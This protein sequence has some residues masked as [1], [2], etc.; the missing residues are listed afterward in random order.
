[1]ALQDDSTCKLQYA[2]HH[3]DEPPQHPSAGPQ[4]HTLSQHFGRY[5]SNLRTRPFAHPG[6]PN[7]HDEREFPRFSCAPR[8]WHPSPHAPVRREARGARL[9]GVYTL[10]QFTSHLRSACS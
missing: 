1:V 9:L 2:S 5:H 3:N 4:R 8:A 7:M 6:A 10:R